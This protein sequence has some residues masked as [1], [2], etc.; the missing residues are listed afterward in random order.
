MGEVS[1]PRFCCETH[2][3]SP[4][5]RSGWR[6]C[7]ICQATGPQRKVVSRKLYPCPIFFF[8]PH[9]RVAFAIVFFPWAQLQPCS[10]NRTKA[11]EPAFLG[12]SKNLLEHYPQSYIFKWCYGGSAACTPPSPCPGS[13]GRV[14]GP[15]RAP[16]S[17]M[18]P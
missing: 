13:G 17:E 11:C 2:C 1:S 15:G 18:S 8:F 7:V 9:L 4:A 5:I 14:R 16:E 3:V 6:K 10:D 12:C